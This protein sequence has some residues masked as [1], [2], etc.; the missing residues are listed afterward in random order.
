MAVAPRVT[1]AAITL[2]LRASGGCQRR[3]A[4]RAVRAVAAERLDATRR[5]DDDAP[6]SDAD[7]AAAPAAP[8]ARVRHG[9]AAPAPVRAVRCRRRAVLRVRCGTERVWAVC[10]PC[11]EALRVLWG[12]GL[13]VVGK[14]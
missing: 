11:C 12:E 2:A 5:L 3:A 1:G 9:A 7:D 14:L 4:T 10:A 13:R 6:R 8:A